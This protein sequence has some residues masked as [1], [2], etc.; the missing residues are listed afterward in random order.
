MFIA[1]VFVAVVPG[2]D[3]F[4]LLVED[5]WICFR[6][7]PC[8]ERG[9]EAGVGI[10]RIEWFPNAAGHRHDGREVVCGRSGLHHHV[11]WVT[12]KV[13]KNGRFESE[14]RELVIDPSVCRILHGEHPIEVPLDFIQE[15]WDVVPAF[16]DVKIQSVEVF[17]KHP[18]GQQECVGRNPGIDDVLVV[19]SGIVP[20]LWCGNH[21]ALGAGV[22]CGGCVD[23]D[24]VIG[25]PGGAS[26]FAGI[27][28]L[29][30]KGSP[31]E[32]KCFDG[33]FR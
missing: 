22:G 28:W 24:L 4:G 3:V 31:A 2:V 26:P 15:V 8:A 16:G 14:G 1:D 6:P 21:C 13:G 27:G 11:A 7:F 9:L 23:E 19:V 33:R 29:E 18:V 17:G 5:V 20:S 32:E 30:F 25:M 10:C 12:Q